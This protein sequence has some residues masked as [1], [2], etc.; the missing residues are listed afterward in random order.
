MRLM[1]AI[2][3]GF[4]CL[5]FA[6]Q[7]K[8]SSI[9]SDDALDQVLRKS[10]LFEGV[11][12]AGRDTLLASLGAKTRTHEDGTLL[13]RLGDVPTRMGIV[14]D[15]AVEV[16]F[17]D[18][19]GELA[20]VNRLGA[21]DMLAESIAYAGEPS[22]VQATAV[23]D[24]RVLW[25]DT[26]K[27]LS[28]AVLAGAPDASRVVANLVR[29]ISRKNVFLNQKAQ[30]LTQRYVRDRIKLFLKDRVHGGKADMPFS[31]SDL[32]RYLGVNRSALS[33][34]LG[35]LRDEGIV[36]L[37]SYSIVVLKEDFLLP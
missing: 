7:N 31:R 12:P 9:V 24:C 22:I 17:Y 11:S 27:L 13:V 1:A 10:R 21:G 35:R 8:I 4:A 25:M 26:A 19:A 28:P 33:R 15:G 3:D 6:V 16:G 34:E 18:E 30:I 14:V 37:E 20:T 36:A 32:A 2:A 23:G 5:E 29:I